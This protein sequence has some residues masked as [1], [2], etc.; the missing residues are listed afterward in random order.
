MLFGRFSDH[1][2]IFFPGLADN[3]KKAEMKISNKEYVSIGMLT[4]FLFFLAEVPVLSFIFG[5]FFQNIVLSLVTAITTSLLFT[6]VI[7]Y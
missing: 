6:I 7:F 4:S 2:E 3:L 5:I 1:L